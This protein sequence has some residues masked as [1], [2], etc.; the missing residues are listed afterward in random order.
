M[1]KKVDCQFH[2]T[3]QNWEKLIKTLRLQCQRFRRSVFILDWL[4]LRMLIILFSKTDQNKIKLHLKGKRY[5]L[6][7]TKSMVSYANMFFLFGVDHLTREIFIHMEMSPV[8]GCKFW[9]VRGIE[10]HWAEKVLYCATPMIG[11]FP[12]DRINTFPFLRL[13]E[14]KCYVRHI[15]WFFMLIN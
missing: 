6:C 3:I 13:K 2:R 9:P 12:R 5:M 14:I 11:N 4:I 10:G 7:T 1:E 15:A 8:K